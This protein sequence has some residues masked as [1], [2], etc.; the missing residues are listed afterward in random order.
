M[1][2]KINWKRAEVACTAGSCVE[3]GYDDGRIL[4]RGS[5]SPDAEPISF[6]PQTWVST[7]LAPIMLGRVPNTVEDTE[8][9]YI[10]H[11]HTVDGFVRRLTFTAE[12][13]EEFTQGV[14][15]GQFNPERL[16]RG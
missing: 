7:V 3:V 2:K 6:M 16:S 8:A 10:W 14:K 13:W 15:A 9:G 11:G 4:V 1:K 5:K 12:D